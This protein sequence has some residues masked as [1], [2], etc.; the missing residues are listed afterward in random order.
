MRLDETGL[1]QGPTVAHFAGAVA[2]GTEE[3]RALVLP[4]LPE[5]YS[6]VARRSEDAEEAVEGV[7]QTLLL[8]GSRAGREAGEGPLLG[9][10]LRHA[11]SVLRSRV[12]V[13]RLLLSGL[14]PEGAALSVHVGAGLGRILPRLRRQQLLALGMRFGDGLPAAVVAQALGMDLPAARV[15]VA[16]AAL[17][18]AEAS[19]PGRNL[20]QAHPE[21]LDE[22]VSTL[23]AGKGAMPPH[24]AAPELQAVLRALTGLNRH[25]A[26]SPAQESA[27]WREYEEQREEYVPTH[28]LPAAPSWLA[29]ALGVLLLF[30]VLVGGFFRY[31][32]MR[33]GDEV[34]NPPP[35]LRADLAL[36]TVVPQPA[37]PAP[38]VGGVAALEAFMP[39]P[40]PTKP[41][42]AYTPGVDT[43]LL[44]ELSGR[45]YYVQYGRAGSRLLYSDL[46]N[47]EALE[48]PETLLSSDGG[49]R[50]AVS[51]M[52]GQVLYSGGGTLFVWD[53]HLSPSPPRPLPIKRGK[54]EV[55]HTPQ[56]GQ[57]LPPDEAVRV[58]AVAWHPQG[59]TVAFVDQPYPSNGTHPY[60]YVYTPGVDTA[61]RSPVAVLDPGDRVSSL[62]WSPSGRHVL[63][64]TARGSLVVQVPTRSQQA[65]PSRVL[66]RGP[67]DVQWSP[68]P[69][70][71]QL[72]WTSRRWPGSNGPFGV[73]NM[74][75]R[76][77]RELGEAAFAAWAVDG[78]SIV[79]ARFVAAPGKSVRFW[80]LDPATR[81]RR[82]LPA[83]PGLDT[84]VH[85]VEFAPNGMHLAYST[86]EGV[87]VAN[88]LT[89]ESARLPGV[90]GLVHE[91]LWRSPLRG[92]TAAQAAVDER[93]T[94]LF[95]ADGADRRGE[96][97]QSLMSLDLKT[98]EAKSIHSARQLEYAVSPSYV[99]VAIA[100]EDRLQLLNL[101]T[102]D[103][104]RLHKLR[105]SNLH[106]GYRISNPAWSPSGLEIVYVEHVRDRTGPPKARLVKQQIR[107]AG[108]TVLL[109]RD[110]TNPPISVAFSPSGRWLLVGDRRGMHL[111]PSGGGK[112]TRL[113]I[114]SRYEWRPDARVDHLLRVALRT[115]VLD[116]RGQ[117]VAR[118][119]VG[120]GQARWVNRNR[121]LVVGK[122]R[123]A[124][125]YD[126]SSGASAPAKPV[127][128]E[129]HFAAL[130]PHGRWMLYA[131]GESLWAQEL[132]SGRREWVAPAGRSSRNLTWMP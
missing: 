78:R 67:R 19:Y 34:R 28:P 88:Y 117:V 110:D 51:P 39:A 82:R 45:L 125:F 47:R 132:R 38:V 65:D 9:W 70:S 71:R 73:M 94:V 52:N 13:D 58:G 123:G 54:S 75:G 21:E 40:G 68:D 114:A 97:Q 31:L 4:L 50:Y 8:A 56:G 62:E 57:R 95:V 126:L 59:R 107:G 35:E 49:L 120:I 29:P 99:H 14:D 23:L 93:G 104:T 61:L 41:R 102:G 85:E 109:Q 101:E 80:M 130:S 48:Q 3:V 131:E 72:L 12:G 17:R 91:L 20:S 116:A 106:F 87:W 96:E 46:G 119:P 27:I 18:L 90:N 44:R 30:L 105:I 5:L 115:E 26:L 113:P 22:Y 100:A 81:A 60:L 32:S 16:E 127:E 43:E 36:A 74:D 98:G 69:A 83:L 79:Y 53:D 77:S 11:D 2:R 103:F 112:L 63:A 84:S 122:Q 64:N 1:Q 89:G 111:L 108:R 6:F 25:I 76:R 7:A 92:S 66:Y 42:P 124:M 15:L 37:T 86:A 128:E 33:A 55:R 129:L 24:E 10:L 118:L 121:L